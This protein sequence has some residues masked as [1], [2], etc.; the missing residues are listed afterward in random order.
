[1]SVVHGVVVFYI[2]E[3]LPVFS[4]FSGN[5]KMQKN[6]VFI[7]VIA[8]VIVRITLFISLICFI[9]IIQQ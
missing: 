8:D 4:S 7:T 5:F 9:Q 3:V 6:V 2:A 1:M